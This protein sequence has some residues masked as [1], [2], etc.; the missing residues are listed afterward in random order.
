MPR[1]NLTISEALSADIDVLAER[2]S[3]GAPNR[4][5]TAVRLLAR[6]IAEEKALRP[7]GSVP[8]AAEDLL[9]RKADHENR[10]QAQETLAK[11]SRR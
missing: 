7:L 1:L 5:A 6:G 3:P 10:L 9:A 2:D 11:R 8:T 4:S